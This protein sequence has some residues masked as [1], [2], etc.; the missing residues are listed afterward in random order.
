MTEKL[1]ISTE[2][3]VLE[4]NKDIVDE[5]KKMSFYDLD[6]LLS[7][8]EEKDNEFREE[9]DFKIYSNSLDPIDIETLNSY[10]EQLFQKRTFING[11]KNLK[12]IES[13]KSFNIH[14]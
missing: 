9:I 8:M 6:S 3:E 5:F 10:K 12:Y 1:K 14:K 11:I 2:N 13:F 7:I 4:A